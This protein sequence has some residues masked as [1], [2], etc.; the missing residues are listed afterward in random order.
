MVAG[1]GD[2]DGEEEA[3]MM[4]YR[5]RKYARAFSESASISTVA[6]CAGVSYYTVQASI[7]RGELPVVRAGSDRLTHRRVLWL[8]ITKWMEDRSKVWVKASEVA[9]AIGV[10]KSSVI[11]GWAK[12]G[13]PHRV[14]ANGARR[15]NVD[16]VRAWRGAQ[17][18]S[19]SRRLRP[20]NVDRGNSGD[21]RGGVVYG[22]REQGSSGCRYVG[23]TNDLK[24]RMRHHRRDSTRIRRPLYYWWRKVEGRGGAVEAVVLQE[25]LPGMADVVEKEWIARG[26]DK[27]WRLLNLTDGGDGGE[28][29]EETKRKITEICRAKWSDPE[30]QARHEASRAKRLGMTVEEYRERVANRVIVS[31]EEKQ[32]NRAIRARAVELRRAQKEQNALLRQA[33]HNRVCLTVGN[34]AFIQ[35]SNGGRVTIDKEDWD[36]VAQY[37]WQVVEHSGKPRVKTNGNG[38]MLMS[39]F[40]VDAPAS[41]AVVNVSGDG[42]DMRKGNLRVVPRADVHKARS[43]LKM[44]DAITSG[45]QDSVLAGV[46]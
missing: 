34:I 21:G 6:R 13:C 2:D 7:E 44:C 36:R 31:E 3:G 24:E 12:K 19:R 33:K 30:Y 46:M 28:H 27:G 22:L 8:D 1:D 43:V 32:R 14:C 23:K 4:G 5:S 25:Y 15:Y 16:D 10:T 18:E 17:L 35:T 39:R 42:M 40:V 41:A 37:V 29:S 9:R 45:A 11:T 38:G 20:K 26:R